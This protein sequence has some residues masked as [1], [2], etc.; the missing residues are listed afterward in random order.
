MD[1]PHFLPTVPVSIGQMWLAYMFPLSRLPEFILGILLARIL[2]EGMWR[3]LRLRYVLPLPF[4]AIASLVALPPVFA[5]GPHFAVPV[6]VLLAEIASR[7]VRDAPSPFR[8]PTLL[9]PGDRSFAFYIVHYVV[10]MY[11]SHFLLGP[12]AAFSAPVATGC[13]LFLLL[14]LAFAGAWLLHHYVE[15]PSVARFSE[16]GTRAGLSP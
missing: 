4:I 16:V 2:K 7:D 6:A 3:P 11:I 8:R 10:I 12:K 5:F 9:Y 13:V 14:P 1:G 15:N